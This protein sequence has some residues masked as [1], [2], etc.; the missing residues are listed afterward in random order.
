MDP[1]FQE[2]GQFRNRF[3]TVEINGTEFDVPDFIVAPP[4]FHLQA[5]S[6][7]TDRGTVDEAPATDIEGTERPCWEGI[8]MGAYEYCGETIPG[9]R[10]VRGDCN[11]DFAVDV[12]DA[13]F[14][15]DFLFTSEEFPSC[16]DA[17]DAN[18]DRVVDISDALYVLD[19]F[20]VGT[21]VP[22]PPFPD[23]G[24]DLESGGVLGC[25]ALDRL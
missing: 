24:R 15:L 10:F 19:S 22:P 7:A 12:R 9:P 4:N 20:F 17:C 2:K 8:D 3:R 11:S 14:N 21:P 23:C 5:R 18:A 1:Y 16:F 13:F 25:E 6:P